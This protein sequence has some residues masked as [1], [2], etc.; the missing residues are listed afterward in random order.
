MKTGIA[1][2][3][4]ST[5]RQGRSGLG[6]E[7][8]RVAVNAFADAHGVDLVEEFIEIETG[9]G[10]D[11][12]D[13][14]PVLKSALDHARRLK[15]PVIIAKLD[16][17]SRDVAFIAGLMAHRV[18]FVVSDLGPDVDPFILHMYAAIAEQE[19]ARISRRTKDG[20][21]VIRQQLAKDGIYT[22]R[23]GRQIT[24]LGNTANL[25]EARERAA[26][27]IGAKADQFAE[28][29]LPVVAAIQS[30]GIHTLGAI[31]EALNRRGIRTARGKTWH[32][33]TVRNLLRRQPETASVQRK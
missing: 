13:R 32:G 8:Q 24:S 30:S 23:D 11:A 17:L 21:G 4:V 1:Y 29:I 14:R 18:P 25:D 10:A 3:R 15:C 2:Y 19:R 33:S 16:R 20:L 31:A 22:T 6:L 7:A 12:L 26:A 9:K 27:V 5:E 28:N